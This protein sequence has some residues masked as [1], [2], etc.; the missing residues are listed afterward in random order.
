[1]RK[2]F[3]VGVDNTISSFNNSILYANLCKNNWFLIAW[4]KGRKDFLSIFDLLINSFIIVS[5]QIVIPLLLILQYD[6][7][8][9]FVCPQNYKG[10]K[11]SKFLNFTLALLLS[12]T[13]Y[14]DFYNM[15]ITFAYHRNNIVK[16][17]YRKCGF[18]MMS[19][20]IIIEFA[21][22]IFVWILSWTTLISKDDFDN[23]I[24]SN[25]TTGYLLEPTAYEKVIN[26]LALSFLTTIDDIFASNSLQKRYESSMDK[27]REENPNRN[28]F[29]NLTKCKAMTI[30]FLFSSL[31][32]LPIG[33]A[34][35]VTYCS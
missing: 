32:F 5:T 6:K 29:K 35:I 13:T 23:I 2:K 3:E 1:M 28:V 24:S 25:S 22:M 20:S 30:G 7:N 8:G 19:F 33:F 11:T 18:T 16:K 15:I 34:S 9:I 14:N 26:I 4:S 27:I 31:I 10:N 21:V 12:M 17:K